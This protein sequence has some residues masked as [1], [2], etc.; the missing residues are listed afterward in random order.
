MTTP[1]LYLRYVDNIFAVFDNDCTCERFLNVLNLRHLHFRSTI[2]RATESLSILYVK[3]KIFDNG[4]EHSVYCKQSNTGLVLNYHANC[5]NVRKSGL[6]LYL[7]DRAKLIC[8]NAMLFNNEV[9]N[10]L[11]MFLRKSYPNYFFG[12]TLKN[13]NLR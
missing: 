7:L 12:F 9:K 10:L 11:R 1:K 6:I 4:F 5:P 3:I 8:K 13:K 2:E